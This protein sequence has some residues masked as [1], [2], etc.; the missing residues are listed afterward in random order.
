M[1]GKEP[2]PDMNHL[3]ALLFLSLLLVRVLMRI[4]GISAY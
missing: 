3:L 4:G 2:Q 1:Q